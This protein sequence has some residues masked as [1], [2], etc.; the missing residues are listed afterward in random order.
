M[1]AVFPKSSNAWSAAC[2]ADPAFAIAARH[3]NACFVF[4]SP[5][6]TGGESVSLSIRDGKV[7][8]DSS[9]LE[10]VE[11]TAPAEIWQGFLA[12]L[13]P[14]LLLDPILLE[15]GGAMQIEGGHLLVA[16]CY[17]AL[18]RSIEVLADR[19]SN[20]EV[21][22]Y[23]AERVDGH[24]A[25]VGRYVRFEVQGKTYR[26]Y[27]ETAGS[28]IP[29]ILQH[30]AGCHG[31]QWRHLME[32]ESITSQYQLFAYDL[33]FH[34]KSVPPVGSPWWEEEYNLKGDFLRD[35]VV[36]FKNALALENPVFMGCSVGGMLALDLARHCAE[37][38]S[39]VISLEGALYVGDAGDSLQYLYHPKV[40]NEFKA[41]LM[42][43][44]MAPTSPAA[45]RNETM[46]VYAAGWPAVFLGDLH[47]YMHDYDL[48]EEAAHIDTSKVAVHIFNGE[49]DAS[50][51]VEMGQAAHEAIPG[52]YWYH[53][54]NM[55]HFP[56]SESPELFIEY[57][58]PV[59]NTIA[60]D[61]G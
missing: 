39:A 35:F 8:D 3:I 44:I 29:M 9:G 12:S 47:Y 56:M 51:T 59:L 4:E 46:Q 23:E 26:V 54:P 32:C 1:S 28:G 50:G 17:Q 43:G 20:P 55:G 60:A 37:H 24:D 2:E 14:R 27:Y 52:S 42:N 40:S 18:M 48:R 57:V 22:T 41:R 19:V 38:F 11:I 34:G 21:A 7:S 25:A 31:G 5:S 16:Q 13:P 30:T 53:M 58:L 61:R 36:A 33:P 6:K 15:A 45:Y 10:R 49:Y